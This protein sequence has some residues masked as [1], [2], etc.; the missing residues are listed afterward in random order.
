M[1]RWRRG[2]QDV[3]DIQAVA[4]ARQY[5]GRSWRL[6]FLTLTMPNA[7][8]GAVLEDE[9]RSFKRQVA[10]WRRTVGVKD[11]FLGGFD[12]YEVTENEEDDSMNV[13]M[14]GVW[15]MSAWWDQAR[16]Q[17]S[18]GRGIA[19]IKTVKGARNAV[20]YVTAYLSKQPIPGVRTR[21]RWGR[22]R[23]A[24][25]SAIHGLRQT[26]LTEWSDADDASDSDDG[27]YDTVMGPYEHRLAL[28][29]EC[30]SFR[31]RCYCSRCSD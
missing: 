5:R 11:H 24:A 18:W 21:E 19:H 8:A 20:R 26:A 14:H 9:V 23:G 15:V 6:V 3:D 7:P 12:Y 2:K 4:W 22:C 30:S 27:E 10:S 28:N 31:G 17:D 13:H 1:K 16:L 25:L 29:L